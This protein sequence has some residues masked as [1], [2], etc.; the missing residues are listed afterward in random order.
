MLHSQSSD[1]LETLLFIR[2]LYLLR[3]RNWTSRQIN[4]LARQDMSAITLQHKEQS[5]CNY[6]YDTDHGFCSR[7]AEVLI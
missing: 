1:L 7:D 6:S 4:M 3:C 5:L 2:D